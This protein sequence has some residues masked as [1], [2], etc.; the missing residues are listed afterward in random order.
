MF[1]RVPDD[2]AKRWK[3]ARKVRKVKSDFLRLFF[4]SSG[5]PCHDMVWNLSL[6]DGRVSRRSF[7]D[8]ASEDVE[9]NRVELAVRDLSEALEEEACRLEREEPCP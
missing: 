7:W 5:S 2:V 4:D 9:L 8:K 3:S 1:A 6:W